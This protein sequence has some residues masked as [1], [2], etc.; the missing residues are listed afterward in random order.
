VQKRVILDLSDVG[1]IRPYAGDVPIHEGI[2]ILSFEYDIETRGI[3]LGMHVEYPMRMDR[4]VSVLPDED[5]ASRPEYSYRNLMGLGIF[6]STIS[7][8][9]LTSQ[10]TFTTTSTGSRHPPQIFIT[11]LL[12]PRC[13]EI[14]EPRQP[15]DT[16]CSQQLE[17][18]TDTTIWCSAASPSPSLKDPQYIALGMNKGIVLIDND[19]KRSGTWMICHPSRWSSDVLTIDWMSPHVVTGGLRNGGIVLYDARSTSGIHRFTHSG[20]VVSLK[21]VEEGTRVVVAGMNNQMAMYDWRMLKEQSAT[22]RWEM[23]SWAK[24]NNT[25]PRATTPVMRFDYQNEFM[26]PLG[27]DVSAELGLVAAAE[28]DGNVSMWSLRNGEKVRKLDMS[29]MKAKSKEE[30]VGVGEM[31]KCLRFVEDENGPPRLMAS[32]GDKIVEWAW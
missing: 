14:G 9:C 23:G 19:G 1:G 17:P 31:V 16:P 26:Y 6:H 29:M 7:S 2:E 20:P 28:D 30:G 10:R 22:S 13:L 8:T 32:K 24:Q 11:N 5:Q 4:L 3:V 18:P 27:F 25:T 21:T 15:I 12:D